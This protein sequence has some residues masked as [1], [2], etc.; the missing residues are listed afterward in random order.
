MKN[1]VVTAVK[2]VG[3]DFLIMPGIGAYRINQRQAVKVKEC[4]GVRQD[5]KKGVLGG[6]K[7]SANGN[8]WKYGV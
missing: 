5:G 8:L 7:G 3:Q 4:Q 2:Q 1:R 6:G